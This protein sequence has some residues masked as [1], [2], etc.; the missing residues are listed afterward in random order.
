MQ[1]PH[2][3]RVSLRTVAA[4][5]GYS[6]QTVSL[7]LR[8][9]PLVP[10][11]TAELVKKAAAKLGYRSNPILSAIM[12]QIG[13]TGDLRFHGKLALL[14]AYRDRDA[15]R[16]HATIPTYV[17]GC[18]QRAGERGYS[19]DRFWLHEPRLSVDRWISILRTRGTRGLVVVGLMDGKK[20]PPHLAPL[21]QAFPAI[22][23]GVRTSNPAL[24]LSCVDHH[25]LIVQAF[26]KAL[27][28]GYRRPAL[29]IKDRIDELVECRFSAA[30]LACQ[31]GL[32]AARRIPA[33][34]RIDQARTNRTVFFDWLDTHRPDVLLSLYNVV[35]PWL[36]E[37]ALRVPADIGVIQ[38]EWR[39]NQ[40]KVAGMDQHNDLVGEAAVDMLVGMI[41]RNESGL[42]AAP[43]ATLLT[44]SWV[45]GQSVRDA[46]KNARCAPSQ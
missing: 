4:E 11:P 44:A 8:G 40:R 28:L 45:D 37:R 1:C 46:P 26:A 12:A 15:F 10:P 5:V 23:T 19:F 20:L 35:F 43:R 41:Q 13:A 3:P 29:V 30:M 6:K 18:E 36:K 39:D 25:D 16:T 17:R 32:P 7:A 38:L 2:M 42:P 9:S 31:R 21:W 22:V 33:F 14:N 24:S 27:A 34:T